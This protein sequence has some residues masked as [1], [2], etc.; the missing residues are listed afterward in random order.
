MEIAIINNGSVVKVGHY[1]SLFPYTVFPDSGPTDGWLVDNSCM[2]VNLFK[3]HDAETEILVPSSPYIEDG[4]VYTVVVRSKT[5]EETQAYIDA[6]AANLRAERDRALTTSDWT[7]VLDA[8]VDRTAWAT[9]RQA[10]RDL[11]E[12]PDFPNVEL[13]KDPHY[14]APAF[15]SML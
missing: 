14:V 3:P 2:K 15:G 9:Y 10:L 12:H 4:W 13:P 1:R 6:K 11:P 5:P 8:P 7:Q